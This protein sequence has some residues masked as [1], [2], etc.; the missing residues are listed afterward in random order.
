MWLLVFPT[1]TTALFVIESSNSILRKN[2]VDVLLDRF[3]EV[4]GGYLQ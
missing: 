4:L 1:S 2:E 3:C